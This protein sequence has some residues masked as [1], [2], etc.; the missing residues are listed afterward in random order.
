MKLQKIGG[1]ASIANAVLTVI[2]LVILLVV[3]P[4]LGLFGPEDSMDPAKG[5]AAW[6]ASPFT[7]FSFEIIYVLFAI[8]GLLV[9]LAL[10]ER[11]QAGAPILTQIALIVTAISCVLWLAAGLVEHAVRLPIVSAKDTSAYRAAMGVYFGLSDGGD[12]AFGWASLVIGLAALK[13]AKL[14]RIL[15]YLIILIGLMFILDFLSLSIFAMIG[16]WLFIIQSVWLGIVL[17]R[18]KS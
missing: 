4:R 1:I 6:A 12:H 14:P 18:T 9:I 8:A 5:I 15:G 10:R 13:T 2:F 3:F 11:M 17:L 16:L 7:F